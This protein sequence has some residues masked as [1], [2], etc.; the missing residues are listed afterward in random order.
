MAEKLIGL[1]QFIGKTFIIKNATPFYRVNDINI[2]GDKAENLGSLK[3][4][5]SFKLD[6]YLEPREAGANKNYPTLIYGK[7]DFYYFTF[8]GKDGNYY[9]VRYLP[10]SSQFDTSILRQQGIKTVE[11]LIA[12]QEENKKSTFQKFFEQTKKIIYI[13]I[14]A[15]IVVTLLK[16]K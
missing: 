4:D 9:A 2:Y 12:E 7:R 15:W 10:D 8:F 5:Y 6:S 14:G 16:K 1:D 13:G 11:E 3:K